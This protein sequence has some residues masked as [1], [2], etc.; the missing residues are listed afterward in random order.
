MKDLG[1]QLIIWLKIVIRRISILKILDV[2]LINDK[3]T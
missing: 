1:S 3:K 2:I